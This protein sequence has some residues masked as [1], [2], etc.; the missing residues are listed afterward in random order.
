MDRSERFVLLASGAVML[1]F[2]AALIY[3]AIGLGLSVPTCVS[4]APFTTG[5]VIDRGGQR[6]EVH[7]VAKMWAFDPPEI[8]LPTG[9]DVDLYVSAQDVTHGVYIEHT[10]V[11]VMAVPGAV[12]AARVRFAT[13]GTYTMLCHEYCGIGHQ[14][15]A[16]KFIIGA[17]PPAAVASAG[18]ATAAGADLF[19]QKGCVACHSRD[20]APGVGP[21]L[22]GVLGRHETL[23]DGGSLVVDEV[24]IRQQL[25]TPNAT[26]IK[27]F[28][29]VMP[30]LP[31]TDAEL[32][33]LVEYVKTL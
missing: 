18:A 12:N 28:Q 19:V 21:T 33:A 11:N 16:G 20:G 15:M 10:N 1:G 26:L 5:Q 8:R 4:V 13:P 3:A 30:A 2:F 6:Y 22:K 31:L 23:A 9:A 17:A 7:L 29:P 32:E 25:R 24:F 14:N 27:G